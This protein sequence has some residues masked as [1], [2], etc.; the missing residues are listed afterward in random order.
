MTKKASPIVINFKPFP[1]QFLAL[2]YLWDDET[3]SV[4]FGGSARSAKTFLLVS[5]SV[6]QALAHK[7][8]N[9]AIGRSRLSYLKK[10]TLLTLFEVFRLWGIKEDEHY[11]FNKSDMIIEFIETGS[12]LIFIE[13]YNNPSDPSYD[14]LLSLT[15]QYVLVDEASQVS[16]T[17]FQTL[18]TRLTP[19]PNLKPKMLI[20]SNPCKGLLFDE[21]YTPFMN[22]TLPKNKKVVL[23]LPQDNLA[24]G[25]EYYEQQKDILVG[26]VK[27]RLLHG[28][29]DIEESEL[30]IFFYNDLVNCFY[31]DIQK[32]NTT[33][34]SCDVSNGNQ[35]PSVI[36][37][38]KGLEIVDIVVIKKPTDVVEKEIKSLITKWNCKVQNCVIDS[39]GLGISIANNIKGCYQFKGGSS[40]LNK[41]NYRNVKDQVILKT[42]ELVRNNEIKFLDK[43][44]DE[45]LKE[46][47]NV[48]YSSLDK[49]RIEVE[50]KEQQKKRL[51]HSSDFMDSIVMRMIFEIKSKNVV[52][53]F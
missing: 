49:E 9:I 48:Q 20:V 18:L 38:W 41:Q 37:I 7:N 35:D 5:F 13:L 51:S 36:S 19:A 53:V 21:Y 14:R 45:I 32:D 1:K 28:R 42:A 6:I 44:K 31:N 34:I 39:S 3:T 52:R 8:I 16:P 27:E 43:Y 17:A 10:T 25:E 24:I 40:P 2:T 50:T 15:L 11:I 47:Q 29:W 46:F 26:A 23:A 30:Q 22:G 4:M 33:Y 12:R